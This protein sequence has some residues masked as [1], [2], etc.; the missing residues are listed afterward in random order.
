VNG[1]LYERPTILSTAYAALGGSAV[2]GVGLCA[3]YFYAQWPLVRLPAD[4]IM[5]AESEMTGNM[6]KLLTGA[7]LYSSPADS[8][9]MIYTP[10]ASL[11]T[12]GV[13][14]LSRATFT[15]PNLR[16]VQILFVVAAALVST[17]NAGALRRLA[18]SSH[19]PPFAATWTVLTFAVVFL[20][21]TSPRVNQFVACLHADATALFVS[22]VVFWSALRYLQRPSRPRLWLMALL[23]GVGYFCKQFMA[24]WIYVLAVFLIADQ[25]R[26]WRR[27]LEFVVVAGAGVGAAFL[28]GYGLWGNDFVFWTFQIM[29]ARTRIE[30]GPTHQIS[31]L[32]GIDHLLRAWPELA[33]GAVGGFLLLRGSTA[34]RLGP[35]WLA[36]FT[37]IALETMS[38]GAGWGVLY[39]FGPGVVIGACWLM[40]ALPSAWPTGVASTASEPGWFRAVARPLL[41]A[42][43]VVTIFVVLHA[44]PTRDASE[45]R[46]FPR[47]ADPDVQRYIGDIE[48]EV[49]S[50]PPDRVLLDVGNWLYL[51]QGHLAR[52][53]AVAL[54]DQPYSGHF[55]NFAGLLD[56][57]RTHAYDVILVHHLHDPQFRYDWY[58]WSRPSGVRAALLE[59]YQEARVIPAA[60]TNDGPID[61]LEFA[62]DVSVLVPKAGR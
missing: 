54:A 58:D 47:R 53:R 11:L 34:A 15:V 37:L 39:H 20:A 60:R 50:R 49:A 13:M 51:Q 56:R 10:G 33:L 43:G 44:V 16:L 3:Y 31:P 32:R 8:N 48:R 61:Y 38:S 19:E 22:T 17:W 5:W 26:N 57:I 27:T 59:H 35:L 6:I 1:I 7:P 46:F 9:S 4:I 41:A 25:P 28:I 62:G 45:A 2:V 24:G 18:R 12:Y 29:G 23:P 30:W 52:D 42:G 14:R 36:W 40:A 21:C 55:E